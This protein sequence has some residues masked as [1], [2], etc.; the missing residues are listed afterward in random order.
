MSTQSEKPEY[1]YNLYFYKV[2]QKQHCR[3]IKIESDVRDEHA[4]WEMAED[5]LRRPG[6]ERVVVFGGKTGEKAEQL[7]AIWRQPVGLAK[8][9]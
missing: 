4:V 5:S 9:T 3:K 6:E 2:R 8:S 1:T 7:F